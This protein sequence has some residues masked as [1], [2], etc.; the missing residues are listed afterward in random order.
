MTPKITN[1]LIRMTNLCHK[2]YLEQLPSIPRTFGNVFWTFGVIGF[3][4]FA[5]CEGRRK[6]PSASEYIR[7]TFQ[8]STPW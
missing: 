2:Y 5:Q 6:A 7:T 1:V 3:G 4:Q 8:N